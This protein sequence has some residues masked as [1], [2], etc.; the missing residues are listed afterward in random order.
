MDTRL[1]EAAANEC[2]ASHRASSKVG[3]QFLNG[4]SPI[5]TKPRMLSEQLAH[6]V[7]SDY[8]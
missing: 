2:R 1:L 4:T 6:E 7:C 8:T 3:G 5:E